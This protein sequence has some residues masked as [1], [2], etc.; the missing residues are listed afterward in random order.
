MQ[1]INAIGRD[2]KWKDEMKL[3]C[4]VEI[5]G[6]ETKKSFSN[7]KLKMSN[8]IRCFKAIK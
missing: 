2:R 8:K 1:E 4:K 3:A 7:S 5:D 6:T